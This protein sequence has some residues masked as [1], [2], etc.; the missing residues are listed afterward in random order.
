MRLLLL[1]MVL[2]TEVFASW[3]LSY[4]FTLLVRLPARATILPF[5]VILLPLVIWSRHDWLKAARCRR[6]E[7][8]FAA[9]ALCFAGVLGFLSLLVAN[10]NPDDYHFFHRA[11]A[12]LDCLDRPFLLTETGHLPAGL[13][14]LSL[15]HAMTSYEPAVALTARLLGAD[16]LGCY[17]NG[18]AL[19]GVALLSVVLTLWYRQFRLGPWMAIAATAVAVF[20][21]A[22]DVRLPRS[23]GNILVYCWT[24]K[25]LLW[26]VLLPWSILLALRFL[27]RP[28]RARWVPL[29]L[30]GVARPG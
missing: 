13:P 1:L 23:Y 3:T 27:R 17:Q 19:L 14:Q 12:Q 10:Y 7:R 8:W 21:L 4:H 15:L 20:Y 25:V 5:L 2:V 22:T 24:G 6:R 16:P 29:F 11:L 30:A 18:G 9:A 28:C 26:G